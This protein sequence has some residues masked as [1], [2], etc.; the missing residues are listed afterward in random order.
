MADEKVIVVSTGE[1]SATAELGASINANAALSGNIDASVVDNIE[2]N[3]SVSINDN[4]N[5]A[6]QFN[7]A[8]RAENNTNGA[9]NATLTLRVGQ[10]GQDGKD[11]FSPTITVEKDTKTE[12]ILRI[13]DVNGSYLTPN[14]YPDLEGLQ[15]VAAL[16]AS[17]VDKDL[18]SYDTL[19]PT[20]LTLAQRNGVYL[21]VNALGTSKKVLLSELALQKETE[22]RI[23]KKLQTVASVPSLEDWRVGD[24][25]LLDKKSSEREE[26]SGE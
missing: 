2:L 11:G 8:L 21:Y 12:Y 17:K 1:V 15:D 7:G 26:D 19:T 4:L 18:S 13:T 23:A 10:D 6:A 16:V 5:G 14:L 3:G 24:Y 9:T 20:H 22:E 25:I